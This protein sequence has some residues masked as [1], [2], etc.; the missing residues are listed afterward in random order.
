M[1]SFLKGLLKGFMYVL[2]LPLG[3]LG[4]SLYMV[5]G[6]FVFLYRFGKLIYLFFTG[7]TLKNEL[8]ED[9]EV[10]KLLENKPEEEEEKY[11]EP[12]MSL[13][14]S[15]SD[16]YKTDYISPTFEEKK[17]VEEQSSSEEDLIDGE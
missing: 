16:M 6:V 13:Y 9:V 3:V 11:S 5:F 10:K 15:D 14:P 7:R 17:E 12:A 2:F 8:K 4:I 1:L